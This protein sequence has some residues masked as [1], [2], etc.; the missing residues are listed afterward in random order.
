M[1]SLHLETIHQHLDDS[2]RTP[3]LDDMYL[4]CN[5]FS[6]RLMSYNACNKNW[7]TQTCAGKVC[8]HEEWF[9][10]LCSVPKG[11]TVARVIPSAASWHIRTSINC[12]HQVDIQWLFIT[13]ILHGNWMFSKMIGPPYWNSCLFWADLV[14]Q[15]LQR[16]HV[17]SAFS[18]QIISQELGTW[19]HQSRENSCTIL[20]IFQPGLPNWPLT[21]TTLPVRPQNPLKP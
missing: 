14:P 17:Q 10:D 13:P 12:L 5:S 20:G 6:S 18:C 2:N 9:G 3:C 8:G 15:S 4:C 16:S 1:S 7:H 21:T 19:K 11:G